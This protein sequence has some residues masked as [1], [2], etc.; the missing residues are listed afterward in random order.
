MTFV[1]ATSTNLIQTI[2]KMN[3]WWEKDEWFEQ[4]P[5]Y[6]ERVR[7][8]PF[9]HRW[10]FILDKAIKQL[11]R[12]E[13]TYD[14]LVIAGPRRTGKTSV[15]KKLIEKNYQNIRRNS[16]YLR[17]DDYSLRKAVENIGLKEIL[18]NAIENVKLN[19]PL[20]AILDEA[21][22]LDNW[23]LHVKNIIDSL[24]SEGK[25][26]LLLVTGSL[27]LRLIRGSTNILAR[28][29]DIP[30][31]SAIANP[32]VILPYKF[33]E[34][35]EALGLIR[36]YIR[37][38]DL[39]KKVEREKIL[40][41]LAK[42][43]VLNS[44]IQRL[45]ILYDRVSASL[46]ALFDAYSVSGGYPLVLYELIIRGRFKQL[47]RKWYS[48]FM[49]SLLQDLKYTNLR[50]DIT[51][52]VL[53]Y[54]S[55]INKLSP[56]LDLNKLEN[57]IRAKTNLS[58]RDLEKFRIEDYV[59]YFNEIFIMVK[60]TEIAQV[61]ETT[62]IARE[63]KLFII[64]PFIIH[65][66][67]FKDY[68]DPLMESRKLLKDPSQMGILVEHTVCGHFLRLTTRPTLYYHVHK[69]QNRTLGEIDCICHYRHTYIPVEVKYTE[70]E[71][72]LRKEAEITNNILNDLNIRSRPII[73]SKNIFEIQ[74]NYAIIPAN[75]FLLLF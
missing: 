46:Q 62:D 14:V 75:T 63:I 2:R 40:L 21:S 12:G 8:S 9:V 47:D 58:R 56:L 20:I 65:S 59:G 16:I 33:S 41:D 38:F 17:L 39:L 30:Y 10:F 36:Q 73:V 42:P 68:S 11:I 48:E 43:N 60:A 66:I 25:K 13:G 22:A 35:A 50:E 45:K 4:D 27:G 55:E 67:M 29:G 69:Q 52:S 61:T 64:D 18:S 1:D 19:E 71:E 57:Y 34:Y 49:G 44:N 70:N 72:M 31:L 5:D 6:S 26:F 3:P 32:G 54:L 23:D 51:R 74:P 53:E 7:K 28:R 24:T 37:F 15:M